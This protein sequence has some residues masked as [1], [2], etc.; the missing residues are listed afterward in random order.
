MAARYW[1]ENGILTEPASDYTFEA[2]TLDVNQGQV[3]I[4]Q[5]ITCSNNIVI[6]EAIPNE[7]FDF[8]HWSDGTTDNPRSI[9][10]EDDMTLV[11]YFNL[12][13]ADVKYIDA[14]DGIIPHKIIL[15]GHIYIQNNDKT[16]TITGAEVK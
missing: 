15:N 4:I 10:V 7:G 6:V 11:A 3:N 9:V 13:G 14:N 5:G 8:S 12:I 16:Y 1:S 2:S